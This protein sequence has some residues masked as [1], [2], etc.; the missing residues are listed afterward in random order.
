MVRPGRGP[1]RRAAQDGPRRAPRWRQAEPP[2]FRHFGA[3]QVVDEAEVGLKDRE[4]LGH[5]L[6]LDLLWQAEV[7][8]R[9][10]DA[11]DALGAG[12]PDHGAAPTPQC[13]QPVAEAVEEADMDEEPHHPSGKAAEAQPA[14]AHDRL[15]PPDGG[16]TAE[17]A[18]LEGDCAAALEPPFDRVGS[19]QA[20]LHGDLADARQ[21]VEVR[22]V[23]DGEHLGVTGQGQ[24]GEHLD[25][26]G[27]VGL[28]SGGVGQHAGERGRLDAS[29]PDRGAALDAALLPLGRL[30]VDPERIDAH[31]A[32]AHAQ[33]DAHL[34]EL[35]GRPLAQAV[36]EVGQRLLAA[37]DQE[38]TDGGR[39]DV[40]EV[41]GQAAGGQLADLPGQLHAGRPAAHDGEGHEEALLGRV[42]PRLGDLEGAEDPPP[43][44]QGVVDGL[45]PRCDHGELVVAE[46]G[47][48]RAGR[49]DQAVVGIV[50]RRRPGWT[51]VCTTRCSRSNPVT[52]ARTT[53]TFLWR[54]I[55]CRSTGAISPGERMPV[56]TW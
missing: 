4:G 25:P 42:G 2:A 9:M 44:L 54:R 8:A 38:D 48:A 49:H 40:P 36:A 46:V 53:S 19:V 32:A 30:G 6:V 16:G 21:V 3:S 18:V 15:E 10:P 55:M 5:D 24:I 1:R 23:A 52:L 51:A 22:H 45:H 28:R 12:V 20:A 13:R 29:R 47:L 31:D 43:Q 33:L 37:V 17:V 41:A 39:V 26:P 50:A 7:A 11:E 56:A 14:D 27:A 34:L 35:L